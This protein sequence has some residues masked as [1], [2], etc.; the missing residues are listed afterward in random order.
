MKNLY[1]FLFI[2]SSYFAFSQAPSNDDCVNAA[3]IVIP[4]SGNI[5][6]TG[7]NATATSDNSTTTCDTAPAGNEIWYTF[8][9]TGTQNTIS[10]TPSG[11]SPASAVV[12][13]LTSSPCASGTF[14]SC[15]A[16]TGAGTAT[17]G[18]SFPVGTQVWFS[19]ETNGTNG[20][21]NVC[22][23]S[24]TPPAAA[25][26]ACATA[27]VVCNKANLSYVTYN[28]TSSGTSF[29]CA[30]LASSQ[31]DIWIKFTVGVTGTL[32]WEGIPINTASEWDW[33]LHDLG[34]AG[35][36]P[37]T[38]IVCN[39]NFAGGS[40]G[41]GMVATGA[42]ADYSNS[43]TVTAG[44]TYAL[45]IDKYNSLADGTGF[46]MSWGGTFQIAPASVFTVSPKQ[47]CGSL[48]ASF[49]NN[50]GS[51]ITSYLWNFGDGTTSTA[52]TP[53]NHTYTTPGNY[54]ISLTTTSATGCTNSSTQVVSVS[55]PVVTVTAAS[56]TVC[57]GT[58]TVLNGDINVTSLVSPISFPQT[59]NTAIPN[60]NTTGI[61][62]NITVSGV[63]PA[64]ITNA[65]IASVCLDILNLND[66]DLDI[67]LTSPCGV[68][69]DLSS[70][71]GG[72]S[73][74]Y[75]N[76][77]FSPTASTAITAGAPPF[78]G[79]YLPEQAFSA[80]NGCNPNGVWT[81]TVKDDA[82]AGVGGTF[83]NWSI[84]FN[85]QNSST[86]VWSP[87]TAMTGST[88]LTPTV[89]PTATTTYTLTA[90]D[91]LGCTANNSV[92]VTVTPQVTPTFTTPPPICS[93]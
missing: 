3:P 33:A 80:F 49:I 70:D 2:L 61:S 14:N 8:T 60:N 13:T 92:T 71:N 83:S 54:L 91:A 51:G 29:G 81:L 78:T 48:T 89:T 25:G 12:V 31:S 18:F 88:T 90:T 24:V 68:T 50:S 28:H 17:T 26:E 36:C 4:A 15:N 27:Q 7:S 76:T 85:T 5:C 79:T 32:E 86:F 73:D 53:P 45:F 35:T 52:V 72:A 59:V 55:A 22:V 65:T 43:I 75:T 63:F 74:N 62:S 19:V 10:V 82:A 37:G 84:A 87:T 34:V 67:T 9:S 20:T 23:T 42:A 66:Q 77:C 58:S 41:F 38:Q 64:V 1:T 16:A 69:I 11:A 30:T 44:R 21:F 47:A 40:T 93:G 6:L 39:Y 57:A 46:N 56:P